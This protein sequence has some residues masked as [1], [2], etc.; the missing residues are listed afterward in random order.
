MSDLVERLNSL[1]AERAGGGP[2]EATYDPELLAIGF[3]VADRIEQL[4]RVLLQARGAMETCIETSMIGH[5][6]VQHFD[7]PA[8]D[9][10]IFA[11]DY[12]LK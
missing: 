9:V 10:A 5:E 1:I 3:A 4:E 8:I 11:I 6:I 12:A 7:A 2:S